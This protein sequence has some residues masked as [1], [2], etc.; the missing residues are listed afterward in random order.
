M[1]YKSGMDFEQIPL[2]QWPTGLCEEAL[3]L[4]LTADQIRRR[5]QINFEDDF[6][7]LDVFEAAILRE[8]DGQVFGI[9]AYA[10]APD[11]GSDILLR[12][13]EVALLPEV[14]H[15]LG[16][17]KEDISWAADWAS[18]TVRRALARIPRSGLAA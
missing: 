1:N 2:N 6:D 10:G 15:L 16:L 9:R 13:G 17:Q 7:D 5:A 4:A 18:P 8:S 3:H 14:I 12:Q 11:G